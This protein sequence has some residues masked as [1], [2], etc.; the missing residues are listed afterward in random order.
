MTNDI[1]SNSDKCRFFQRDGAPNCIDRGYECNLPK[2]H[3]GGHNLGD[4]VD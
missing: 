2:G 1:K 3:K 4:L